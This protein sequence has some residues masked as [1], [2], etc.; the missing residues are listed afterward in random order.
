MHGI[1]SKGPPLAAV[2]WGSPT[3]LTSARAQHR[4][5]ERVTAMKIKILLRRLACRL[6][7]QGHVRLFRAPLG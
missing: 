6:K 3:V 1:P 4:K 5:V 7:G 2:P